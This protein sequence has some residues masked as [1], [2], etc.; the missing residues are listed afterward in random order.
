[1]TNFKNRDAALNSVLDA[2]VSLATVSGIRASKGEG[3]PGVDKALIRA[4]HQAYFGD[5]SFLGGAFSFERATTTGDV[6]RI[7]SGAF[8]VSRRLA[9]QV[10][11]FG[12]EEQA[13]G[14]DV[15]LRQVKAAFEWMMRRVPVGDVSVEG[16]RY[17]S[18]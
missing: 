11:M 6:T 5:P 1:M 13:A 10:A 17:T 16:T 8:D 3:P 14:A 18:F 2:I 12:T 15:Q 7:F 9:A 4:S